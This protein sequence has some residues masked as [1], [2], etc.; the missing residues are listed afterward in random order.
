MATVRQVLKAVARRRWSVHLQQNLIAPNSATDATVE[1]LVSSVMEAVESIND[2]YVSFTTAALLVVNV[3][4]TSAASERAAERAGLFSF[5]D[6]MFYSTR[7]DATTGAGTTR[8]ITDYGFGRCATV[9][10]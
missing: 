5:W 7:H 8:T 6:Q 4:S 10:P 9:T 1:P 3:S 2:K